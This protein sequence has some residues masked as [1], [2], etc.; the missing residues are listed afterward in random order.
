[1]LVTARSDF[2]FLREL[3]PILG[4][5]GWE[6]GC[7][8]V[9]VIAFRRTERIPHSGVY[10]RSWGVGIVLGN[11][12]WHYVWEAMRCASRSSGH[13]PIDNAAPFSEVYRE[14]KTLA[15][16]VMADLDEQADR[17]IKEVRERRRS[18]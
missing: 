7:Q 17:M 3:Y 4:D 5:E 18:Q 6:V 14:A 12:N 8:G 10:P 16:G 15:I 1:M 2:E 11:N 13:L 9:G